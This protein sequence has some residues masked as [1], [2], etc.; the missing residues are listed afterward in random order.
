VRAGNPKPDF[1]DKESG[2]G[3][4]AIS[5]VDVHAVRMFFLSLL[6]RCAASKRKEV[7]AIAL[8]ADRLEQLR[9]MLVED[10]HTPSRIYP[11][12]LT[13]LLEVGSTHN[14]APLA[15]TMPSVTVEGR[16]SN[17]IPVFRFYIDGLIANIIREKSDEY[18]EFPFNEEE[19][20]MVVL[21]VTTDKSFER[22]NLA[23]NVVESDRRW[24]HVISNF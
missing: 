16:K 21:T 13:Q 4:R 5:N 6:W 24:R 23:K 12:T 10:R 3:I 18:G 20:K 17:P 15:M 1:F 22:M 7:E 9:R 19:R 8:S 14:L 11:F 2:V